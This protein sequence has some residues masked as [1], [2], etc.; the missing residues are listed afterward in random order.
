M[1]ESLAEIHKQEEI[2][3]KQRSRLQ[4]LKEVDKN[5]KY[6]HSVANGRK[7]INFIP[8]INIGNVSFSDA[9]DIGKVFEQHF[10]ALFGQKRSFRFKVDL[11]NLLKNKVMVDLSSSL[12]GLSR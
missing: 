3:W 10:R 2:Y 5:L 4:W 9:R 1:S 12:R 7:N 8:S 6:F 11:V